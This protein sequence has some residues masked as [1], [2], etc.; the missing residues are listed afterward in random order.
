MICRYRLNANGKILTFGNECLKNWS[1]ISYALKR[2]GYGGVVRSFSSA[3]QFV[4]EA[5]NIVLG[6]YLSEYLN[7][8][9]TISV[10]TINDNHSYSLLYKA[11]LDYGTMR[12]T[13][14]SVEINSFDNSFA[15]VIKAKKSTKYEY[16]MDAIAEAETLLYD[17]MNMRN[18]LVYMVPKTSAG[19]E[20]N[21]SVIDTALINCNFASNGLVLPMYVKESDYTV[22][23]SISYGDTQYASNAFSNLPS[24]YFILC[25]SDATVHVRMSFT[26]TNSFIEK[27]S[28]IARLMK[29]DASG[30][31]TIIQESMNTFDDTTLSKV[32]SV[33][34]DR[35]IPLKQGDRL[36][37]VIGFSLKIGVETEGYMIVRG[38]NCEIE[39]IDRI[40]PVTMRVIKPATL[41]NSLL[42][43][44]NE[45]E[46]QIT[47]EI[48]MEGDVRLE[49]AMILPSESAKRLTKA[50]VSTSFSQFCSWMES[51]FGYVYV[52]DGN[53]IR[54]LHRDKLFPSG[55]AVSMEGMTNNVEFSVNDSLI[56]SSVKAGCKKE[57]YDTEN[58]H[59][60]FHWT[61][62]YDTGVTI[63]ESALEFIS[64]YRCDAYGIE[65]LAEGESSS[66]PTVIF[67]VAAFLQNGSY[68]LDRSAVVD[69]VDQK[70]TIFNAMYSPRSFL[71]ANKKYIGVCA[72][73]L[74][75]VSSEG[76][77]DVSI[78]G[79]KESALFVC[80]ERLFTVGLLSFETVDG[81]D[82]NTSA[83]LSVTKN[84]KTYIGY[85]NERTCKYG[86]YEGMKYELLINRIE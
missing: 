1:E 20:E 85:M 29:V 35:D 24:D 32:L 62:E 41:L 82:Y 40:L 61:A 9:V 10:Y 72:D 67:F 77:S 46:E 47:G 76:N 28:H 14:N 43:S 31:S 18:R 51:V 42:S 22:K 86:R 57:E 34:I 66:S 69:G 6:A 48:D 39:W 13:D 74:K 30:A 73:S 5:Y 55:E 2:N 50:K 71:E 7:A 63:K 4:G 78:D 27:G 68:V 60:E 52:Q 65:F 26:M 36:L 3:F 19:T 81:A 54:F 38:F 59:D 79:V 33:S 64:P 80:P 83:M 8:K 84:G 37:M 11:R 53:V 21:P 17:G 16:D 70:E 23:R 44:M 45:T 56:Y 49:R 25:E 75:F 12:L 58:G 15:S